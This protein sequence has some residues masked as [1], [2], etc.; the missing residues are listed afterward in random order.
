MVK[1]VAPSSGKGNDRL[2]HTMVTTGTNSATRTLPARYP[3]VSVRLA[4]VKR[5][6]SVQEPGVGVSTC[7]PWLWN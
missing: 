3:H 6:C 2:Y 7:E 4:C 1:R 5:A